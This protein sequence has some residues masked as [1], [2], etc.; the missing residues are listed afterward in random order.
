MMQAQTLF[1]EGMREQG[2][3]TPFSLRCLV[4][5]LPKDREV[6]KAVTSAWEEAFLI[7]IELTRVPPA[8][9][10]EASTSTSYDLVCTVWHSVAKGSLIALT[11]LQDAAD[12]FNFSRWCHTPFS[13]LIARAE[14]MGPSED[15]RQ[16]LQEAEQMLIDEMPIIPLFDGTFRFLDSPSFP[17]CILSPFGTIDFQRKHQ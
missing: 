16:V 17:Q 13:D 12:P 9:F 5:D 4:A 2:L 7:T 14:R 3:K 1:R 6:A 8:L 11:P 15:R 10:L